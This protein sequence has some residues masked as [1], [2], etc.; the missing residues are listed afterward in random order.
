MRRSRFSTPSNPAVPSAIRP[1]RKK[2]FPSNGT[3]G[4]AELDVLLM[5]RG[6]RYG[7][8]CRFADAPAKTRS[9]HV[10]M[11]DLS[12]GH[13]WI[14]YPGTERYTLDDRITALPATQLPAVAKQIEEGELQEGAT[15]GLSLE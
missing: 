10:A 15:R 12:L 9:M 13:L 8:E 7:F 14:V 5:A 6:K 11:A 2:Q 4:G 3:H 1:I